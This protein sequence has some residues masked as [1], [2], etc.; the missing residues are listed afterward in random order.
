MYKLK[1][2]LV[3]VEMV[4]LHGKIG[5]GEEIY[6]NVP[7]GLDHK[8]DECLKLNKTIYGLVQD[9]EHFLR[10]SPQA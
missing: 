9:F 2:K 4:F 1:L 8:D 7:E 5:E 3:D 6:M 10:L